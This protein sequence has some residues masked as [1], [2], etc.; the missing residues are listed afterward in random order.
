MA[1]K[2]REIQ[3]EITP[4][5]LKFRA[6]RRWQITLRRYLIEKSPCTAY[7]PYFGID[8]LNFRKWTELQFDRGLNWENFGSAWQF[9]HVVPVTF[10]DF[11]S[12]ADMRMCWNFIN[13]RV[14]NIQ[15]EA[16]SGPKLGVLAAKGYFKTLYEKT[17]LP[18][19]KSLLDRISEIE[20]SE[21]ASS[22]QQQAFIN[23]NLGY[24]TTI[25]DFVEY[26]FD[27]LNYGTPIKE[28]LLEREF[29]NKYK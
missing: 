21:L 12:D 18:V 28:I 26:E 29:I 15:A 14:E 3:T 11:D 27:K 25:S 5:L 17:G 10:F 13:I 19:A 7:A 8:I 24:L 4:E 22:K 23:E 1:R 9:D 6:K 16:K 20:L 2:K